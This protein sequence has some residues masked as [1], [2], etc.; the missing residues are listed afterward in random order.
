MNTMFVADPPSTSPQ[1]S[2]RAIERRTASDLPYERF[3]TEYLDRNLPVIISGAAPQ[4]NA[5]RT[6]TPQ[7]F[8]DRFGSMIVNV[9]YQ[10]KMPMNELI[11]AILASTPEKPGPYLHKVLIYRDMPELLEDLSPDST[12]AF[13]RRYAGALMPSRFQRPDGFLKLLIGGAGGKFPLMHYDTDNSHAMITEIYGD[14]EFILF[15]P[16]DTKYMYPFENSDHTSQIEN[17]DQADLTKYPLFAKA[18][19]YRGTVYPGDAIL[20]PSAWWH[21]AR[22]LNP[23]ISVCTNMM[24]RS[25]WPGFI[26]QCC[27]PAVMKNPL[28]RTIKRVYLRSLGSVLS[29]CE[30]LQRALPKGGFSKKLAEFAPLYRQ[31][32]PT[33][34]R[35]PKSR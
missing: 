35:Y 6:W 9:S 29:A 5:M 28:N 10:T 13:P 2:Y 8:K 16:E 24:Y 15:P 22:A 3:V 17:P 34:V 33:E 19:Q 11:D 31:Q 30:G 18:T 26:D 1:L 7:F 21:A 4:W 14:K 25:N 23:S 12:Y 20:I 27:D 32:L